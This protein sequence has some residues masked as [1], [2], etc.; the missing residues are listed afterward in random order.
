M[1][2]RRRQDSAGH[3]PFATSNAHVVTLRRWRGHVTPS[4]LILPG[5]LDFQ[6][7][8]CVRVQLIRHFKT[9]TTDIYLQKDCA[10]VGLSVHAPASSRTATERRHAVSRASRSVR[11]ASAASSSVPTEASTAV[12]CPRGLWGCGGADQ[13]IPRPRLHQGSGRP[14]PASSS[15]L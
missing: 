1:L 8:G 3:A 9:C 12:G 5:S 13:H 15:V 14:L 7:L 2:I 10:H 4:C 11:C 6:A